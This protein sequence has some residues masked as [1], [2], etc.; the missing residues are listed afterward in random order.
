M[1]LINAVLAI[2]FLFVFKLMTIDTL[3]PG[4]YLKKLRAEFDKHKG[5]LCTKN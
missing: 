3:M 1:A 4:P 5:N 2:T